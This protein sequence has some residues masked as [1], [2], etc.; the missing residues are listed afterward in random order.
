MCLEMQV[1]FPIFQH[2]AV[3]KDGCSGHHFLSVG[4]MLYIGN[5][6]RNTIKRY[7]IPTGWSTALSAKQEGVWGIMSVFRHYR[8]SKPQRQCAAKDSSVITTFFFLWLPPQ[9]EIK[10]KLQVQEEAFNARIEKLKKAWGLGTSKVMPNFRETDKTGQNNRF[11][12]VLSC[13]HE[14]VKGKPTFLHADWLAMRSPAPPV[15][16]PPLSL[17]CQ[18]QLH[19][20]V[21][22]SLKHHIW[23]YNYC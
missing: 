2:E 10:E 15:P 13:L 12:G 18:T 17:Q 19:C 9:N 11:S 23:K 22:K 14:A 5:V 21:W 4:D 20:L 7:R 8:M 3:L 1:S 6:Q 16:H